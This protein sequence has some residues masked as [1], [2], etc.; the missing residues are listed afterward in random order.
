MAKTAYLNV[1]IEPDLKSSVE[2]ILDKIGVSTSEAI[3]L[4]FS[5]IKMQKGIPFE[6]KVPNR[7]TQKAMREAKE[8]KNMKSYN[9]V[10]EFANKYNAYAKGKRN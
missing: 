10:E 1:R 6:A 3:S 4:F 8:N 9:S 7:K 2:K 5:Q